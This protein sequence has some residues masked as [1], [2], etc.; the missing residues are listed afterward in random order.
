[1]KKRKLALRKESLRVLS[2]NQLRAVPGGQSNE[3]PETAVSSNV[4]DTAFPWTVGT[5]AA[6]AF[7]ILLALFPGPARA[8]CAEGQ[9]RS[10]SLDGCHL[11]FYLCEGGLWG[12][13]E[14][15]DPPPPPPPPPPITYFDIPF[16]NGHRIELMRIGSQMMQQVVI[17]LGQNE[18][19]H[20]LAVETCAQ[21]GCDPALAE[22]HC[23]WTGSFPPF[24]TC[25]DWNIDYFREPFVWLFR[26]T[27]GELLI[28]W[29]D[30]EYYRGQFGV[31][32]VATGDFC[33]WMPWTGPAC[34][35]SGQCTWPWP[36][37]PD[38]PVGTDGCCPPP[39]E[40]CY[41]P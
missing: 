17:P 26:V 20:R 33:I 14:C 35:F 11:A 27:A 36:S 18:L 3:F 41:P 29:I 7:A 38:C 22:R 31:D 25:D 10:C 24:F 16:S 32:C 21:I 39:L 9:T 15:H 6:I 12:D 30:G 2:E 37:P 34:T 1:M 28:Q 40:G 8:N 4:Q 13:C 5:S 19:G 23:G